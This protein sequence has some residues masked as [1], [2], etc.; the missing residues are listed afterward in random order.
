MNVNKT[1]LEIANGIWAILQPYISAIEQFF[2]QMSNKPGMNIFGIHYTE[3]VV[4]LL[5]VSI[6]FRAF[7]DIG[8]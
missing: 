4:G 6:L 1:A 3:W 7:V 2:S 8:D 5:I